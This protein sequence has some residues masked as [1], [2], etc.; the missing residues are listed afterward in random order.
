M[1]SRNLITPLPKFTF[2][3]ELIPSRA[4][5]FI[6]THHYKTQSQVKAFKKFLLF[7][8]IIDTWS[9]FSRTLCKKVVSSLFRCWKITQTLLVC[10]CSQTFFL[11]DHHWAQLFP[12]LQRIFQSLFFQLLTTKEKGPYLRTWDKDGERLKKVSSG[13]TCTNRHVGTTRLW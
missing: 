3:R 8:S 4:L 2:L 7:G 9:K 10:E 5:G 6:H 11:Q 1:S 12:L 13:F